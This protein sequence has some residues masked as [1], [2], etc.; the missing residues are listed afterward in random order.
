MDKYLVFDGETCNTPRNERG[1]LD[2]SSG[3]VYDLGGSV[4]DE[5]ANVYDEFSI[6]N[7]DVFFGLK[8]AMKE[9]YYADKIPQYMR[10][11]WAKRR[12][13]VNTWEMWKQ[14]NDLIRR[15]D[16][17][18]VVA[19]NIWFDIHTLNA[20]MRYQTKSKKRFFLPYG[21]QIMDTMR[22]AEKTI[23]KR[24]DYIKFCMENGYMTE[25]A[26]PKP[27]KSAEVLW[28]YLTGDNTFQESH[29]GLED[30]KIEAQIFAECMRELKR[31]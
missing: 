12:K 11:I 21:I 25:Q 4:I 20:T 19:H 1:Q 28:R 27:R 23:C 26:T 8:E 24:P 29:T 2:T 22:M 10:D 18:A 17:K 3:Q 5:C 9:A 31:A 30:V 13:V 14:F 16:I 15:H 7:E 6:V